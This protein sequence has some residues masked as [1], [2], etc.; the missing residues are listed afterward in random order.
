MAKAA[1]VEAVGDGT[2]VDVRVVWDPPWSP[3][4]MDEEAAAGLGFRSR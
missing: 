4:L 1:I 2:A 3:T